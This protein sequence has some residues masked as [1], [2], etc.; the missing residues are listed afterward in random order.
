[1]GENYISIA[2]NTDFDQRLMSVVDC[3][4]LKLG[5]TS[6]QSNLGL[7]HPQK[8]SSNTLVF[9]EIKLT[10]IFPGLR[11]PWEVC[12]QITFG[13]AQKPARSNHNQTHD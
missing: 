9:Q 11:L 7:Y 13:K 10:Y 8:M 12:P 6:M 5:C 3:V 1:M 4:D 2:C